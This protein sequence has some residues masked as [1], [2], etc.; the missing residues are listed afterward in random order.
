MNVALIHDWLESYAGS[1]K[2][3]EQILNIYPDSSIYS[4]V[5]FL[6]EKQRFFI[7]N[8]SVV[9]SFIQRLPGSKKFFRNYFSMFPLAIEQFD[10]SGFDLIISSNHC[11]AKGVITGPDQLHI[12]YCHSPVRYAWDLQ[13]LYLAE[14]GLNK[15]IRSWLVRYLLFNFRNWDYRSASGVDYFIANSKYIARRIKKIYGRDS[16]VIYPNV[17]VEAF[18]LK[19]EKENFYLTASRLVPYKKVD[20]I[21]QA[22]SNML[23]KKLVVMAMD[24][25]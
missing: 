24:H 19:E 4:L 13:S 8:K 2:V 18:Q 23:D 12:C 3:L 15:G 7:K 1:E 14:S 17:A 10:L 16:V 6:E 20:L 25:K 21:V 11:A 9:S 5:D 22:F